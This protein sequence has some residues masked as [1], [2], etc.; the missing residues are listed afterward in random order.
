MCK[1]QVPE[2]GVVL[3][4]EKAFEYE[5]YKLKSK[6]FLLAESELQEKEIANIEDNQ[7]IEENA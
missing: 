2:E 1:N 7:I 6:R 3:R 4:V 5:A